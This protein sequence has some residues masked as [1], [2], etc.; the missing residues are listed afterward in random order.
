MRSVSR[1]VAL[2][3]LSLSLLT[4][5]QTTPPSQAAY[6][7]GLQ[8]IQR[9]DLPSAKKEL[10]LSV[11]DNPKNADA[12]TALG[13]VLLAGNDIDAAIEHLRAA[14]HLQPANARAHTF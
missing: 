9:G 8:S 10:Q 2:A 12:Q 13:W 14:T 1:H 11:R 5:A 7:R 3:L 6:I 4:Q